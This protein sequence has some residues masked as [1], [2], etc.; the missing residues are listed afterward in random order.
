MMIHCQEYCTITWYALITKGDGT[1]QIKQNLRW[2]I[3]NE[4]GDEKDIVITS[5]TSWRE[6]HYGLALIIK[7]NCNI[8]SLIKCL[9]KIWNV[10][11]LRLAEQYKIWGFMSCHHEAIMK[12]TYQIQWSAGISKNFARVLL[13]DKFDINLNAALW[14]LDECK[15]L[16]WI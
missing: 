1:K 9:N 11:G 3:D 8:I 10:Q 16:S 13:H 14:K 2:S 5:D 6:F 7:N 15:E 12:A 4:E